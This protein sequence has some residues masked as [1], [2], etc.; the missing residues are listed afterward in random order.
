MS[1]TLPLHARRDQTWLDVKVQTG[2]SPQCIAGLQANR[3][4]IRVNAAPERGKANKAIIAILADALHLSK[5][6]LEIVRGATQSHK[7]ISI[8]LPPAE[9][10][11]RLAAW[12]EKANS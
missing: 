4:K 11:A 8:Q 10:Q 7:T 1:T 5:Q 6:A 9:M 3:L 2:A 12:L